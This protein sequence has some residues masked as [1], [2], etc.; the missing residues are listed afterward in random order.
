MNIAL[1]AKRRSDRGPRQ[2]TLT[3]PGMLF[4]FCGFALLFIRDPS[5]LT[6]VMAVAVP[7]SSP[8]T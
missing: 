8:L 3:G 1:K 4:A 6:G 7:L 5:P 2:Y